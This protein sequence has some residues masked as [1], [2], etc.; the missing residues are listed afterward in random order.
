M[1]MSNVKNKKQQSKK[2]KGAETDEE[3]TDEEEKE[4]PSKKQKPNTIKFQQQMLFGSEMST[5]FS[6]TF[7]A[8]IQ[9]ELGDLAGEKVPTTTVQYKPQNITFNPEPPRAVVAEGDPP[10]LVDQFM[11]QFWDKK[12]TDIQKTGYDTDGVTNVLRVRYKGSNV[13]VIN[14]THA[15][16]PVKYALDYEAPLIIDTISV[17]AAKVYQQ[18]TTR[19]NECIWERNILRFNEQLSL[20]KALKDDSITYIVGILNTG[21]PNWNMTKNPGTKEEV[22]KGYQSDLKKL[23][24]KDIVDYL[25]SK[26]ELHAM[27]F[28]YDKVKQACYIIDHAPTHGSSVFSKP[29]YVIPTSYVNVVVKYQ[30]DI[31][32]PGTLKNFEMIESNH[33]RALLNR[34]ACGYDELDRASIKNLEQSFEKAITGYSV[35]L[36]P[37]PNAVPKWVEGDFSSEYMLYDSKNMEVQQHIKTI[38]KA[39]VRYNVITEFGDATKHI[40]HQIQEKMT[41]TLYTDA[42]LSAILEKNLLKEDKVYKLRLFSIPDTQNQWKRFRV[43]APGVAKGTKNTTLVKNFKDEIFKSS[44]S[45]PNQDEKD[46]ILYVQYGD[47]YKK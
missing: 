15:L 24:N 8:S 4:V 31:W 35:V 19:H 32:L 6:K 23:L 41:C 2:N 29:Y 11:Y 37:K 9:K 25:K 22:K 46:P 45:N 5:V 40:P 3:E 21:T 20:F 34:M 47:N 28:I 43:G 14:W 17:Q 39:S 38:V 10:P 44:Y 7:E 33:D 16:Y 36:G 13:A 1:S 18:G 12:C 42:S 30:P 26:A 27:P